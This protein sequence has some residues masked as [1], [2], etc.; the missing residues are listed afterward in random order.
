MRRHGD[1]AASLAEIVQVFQQLSNFLGAGGRLLFPIADKIEYGGQGAR[2]AVK[3]KTL[4]DD[5]QSA[6]TFRFLAH[7]FISYLLQAFEY[8]GASVDLGENRSQAW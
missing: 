4:D 2:R 8:H 6:M 5:L 1:G 3:T 7:D